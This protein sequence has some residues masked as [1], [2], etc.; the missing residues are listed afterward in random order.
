MFKFYVSNKLVPASIRIC[1]FFNFLFIIFTISSYL[2]FLISIFYTYKFKNIYSI[3]VCYICIVEFL[4]EY[5]NTLYALDYHQNCPVLVENH[6]IVLMIVFLAIIAINCWQYIVTFIRFHPHIFRTTSCRY[7][8]KFWDIFKAPIYMKRKL[9]N[10]TTIMMS[11]NVELI[12]EHVM[13][14]SRKDNSCDM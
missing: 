13:H 1:S 3:F 14:Q 6:F 11:T 4:I 7:R 9:R 12:F 2:W 5:Q 8:N 10:F